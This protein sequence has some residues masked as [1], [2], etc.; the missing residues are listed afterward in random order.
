MLVSYVK[1]YGEGHLMS[2]YPNTLR[3]NKAQILNV[4]NGINYRTPNKH[5]YSILFVIFLHLIIR[6]K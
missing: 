6:Y 1:A 2:H 5:F 4:Y 3:N